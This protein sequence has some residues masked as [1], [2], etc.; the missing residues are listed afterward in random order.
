MTSAV[1]TVLALDRA[2]LLAQG[3]LR[4]TFESLGPE[5]PALVAVTSTEN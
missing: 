5:S 3:I 4:L 2:T 1:N